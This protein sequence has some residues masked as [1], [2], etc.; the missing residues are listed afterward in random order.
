MQLTASNSPRS[1]NTHPYPI[2]LTK[3]SNIATAAAAKVHRVMLFDAAAVPVALG[4][5]STIRALYV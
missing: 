4:K 3:G 1:V 2:A 5:I